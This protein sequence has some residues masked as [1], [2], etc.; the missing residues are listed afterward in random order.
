MKNSNF[1]KK[2]PVFVGLFCALGLVAC[3]GVVVTPVPSVAPTQAPTALPTLPPTETALPVTETPAPA[4]SEYRTPDWFKNAVLYEIYVRS[5]ADSDGNGIGDF[6]GIQNR[7]DYIQALGV[8]VIWLMPIH[9]SVSVHGYDVTDYFAVHADY[10]TLA[11]FQALVQAV[12]EKG[13]R[14]IIDFVPSHLSNQNPIFLDAY[15]NPQSKYSKWFAWLNDA[16]TEYTG[17]NGQRDMPR[18][19]HKNPEAAQYLIDSALFWLDLDADGDYQDGIDG[20][21]V[22]NITFPPHEF[23]QALRQAVKQANPDA[24]LLGEAWTNVSG[25]L[26]TFMKDEYDSVFNFPLYGTLSGGVDLNGDGILA[27]AGTVSVLK[28]ALNDQKR[29]FP[30]EG[31]PL[32]FYSNHDTNRTASEM[33]GNWE[34]QKLVISFVNSLPGAYMIYY[35]EEIGMLGEKGR[36]PFYDAYRREP[37]DWYAA[38]KGTDQAFWFLEADRWN[39]PND[40]ISVEEQ[41]AD[42]NSLLNYYRKIIALRKSLPVLQSGTI[43]FV[44]VT[45]PN[46]RS[47]AFLR[48]SEGQ[49]VLVVFN[50]GDSETTL[51]LKNDALSGTATDLLS[52]ETVATLTAGQ[53][54]QLTIPAVTGYW[55]EISTP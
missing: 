21:R 2:M 13:M 35:G 45:D 44:T 23:H 46:K 30:A 32:T 5:Y 31:I 37:M 52:G 1:L 49:T 17:F 10:G 4:V 27:G 18:F 15:A 26:A 55:L 8:D 51:S 3:G 39:A 7:L 50:L 48:Q 36:A 34:R 24:L 38:E 54:L 20:F 16:H 14:I 53:D 22:D 43:E 12:H 11:D 28:L 6:T 47:V 25:D 41:T 33:D 40:G 9:P 19:Y 42:E 29:M